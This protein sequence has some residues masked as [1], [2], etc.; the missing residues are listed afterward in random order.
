MTARRWPKR[1]NKLL[2]DEGL[3]SCFKEAAWQK[4]Q[5]FEM[6]LQAKKLLDVYQQAREDQKANLFV[7][8]NKEVSQ[9]AKRLSNQDLR[10]S[11]I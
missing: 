11:E 8:V 9:L 4:A 2:G 1:L 10:S 7:P 6:K 5:S 3:M